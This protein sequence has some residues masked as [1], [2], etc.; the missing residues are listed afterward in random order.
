MISLIWN[1]IL[2]RKVA[3]NAKSSGCKSN[4]FYRLTEVLMAADKPFKKVKKTIL[5]RFLQESSKNKTPHPS[6]LRFYVPSEH[7]RIMSLIKM[8]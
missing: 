5:N 4:Y 3:F 7:K 8:N 1:E 2:K 6:T